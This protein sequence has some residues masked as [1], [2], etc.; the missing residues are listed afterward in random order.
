MRGPLPQAR[1]AERMCSSPIV[2]ASCNGLVIV[3]L[4]PGV[5]ESELLTL[6]QLDLAGPNDRS[7]LVLRDFLSTQPFDTLRLDQL[8]YLIYCGE[9]NDQ[10]CVG[11][12]PSSLPAGRIV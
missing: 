5:N 3:P 9:A 4:R 8:L 1:V 11:L 7:V 6:G 10:Y 12:T 2:F